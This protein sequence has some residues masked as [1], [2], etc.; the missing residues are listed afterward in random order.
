MTV[1]PYASA[2]HVSW[3]VDNGSSHR[4]RASVERLEG[5]WPTSPW[6]TSPWSTCPSTPP[7]STK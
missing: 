1:E 7:G 3:I 4:G 6:P 2:K 5:A